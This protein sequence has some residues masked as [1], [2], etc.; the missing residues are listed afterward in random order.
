[1]GFEVT[2]TIMVVDDS[3]DDTQLL[4]RTF[5]QLGISNPVVTFDTARGGLEYLLDT[6][7][8][9][10]A[11]ILLDLR[12]PGQDGF[13]VLNKLKSH[14]ELKHLIV[15]VLTVSSAWEDVRLAYELGAN[16]FLTKPLDLGEFRAMVSAFHN[17][18]VVQNQPLPAA[19]LTP[20]AA[21]SGLSAAPGT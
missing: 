1:M 8:P 20:P 16:S 3:A 4:L 7:N 5:G 15:I 13:Y 9:R 6:K 10:P 19:P 12:M 11:I 18:W 2:K 21:Q 14:A 17:Y